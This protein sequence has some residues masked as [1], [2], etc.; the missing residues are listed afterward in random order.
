MLYA[1]FYEADLSDGDVTVGY[2]FM[3]SNSA[4]AWPHRATLIPEANERPSW[5]STDYAPGG[6]QWTGDEE[7]KIVRAVKAVE[8]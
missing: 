8:T 5:L 3:V 2:E 6:S 7:E 4:R 1:K